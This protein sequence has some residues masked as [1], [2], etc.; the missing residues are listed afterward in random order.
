MVNV[1]GWKLCFD[2]LIPLPSFEVK[3]KG[4]CLGQRSGQGQRLGQD[5]RLRSG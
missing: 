4:K 2:R 1:K 5:R 3:V